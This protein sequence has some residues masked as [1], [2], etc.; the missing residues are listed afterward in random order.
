ML[1]HREITFTR[2]CDELDVDGGVVRRGVAGVGAVLVER[3]RE[4]D[5]AHLELRDLELLIGGHVA[6]AG[7]LLNKMRLDDLM[8]LSD[9]AV[10]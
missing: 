9:E 2:V 10:V 3:R 5:V 1:M 6:L 8:I 4:A 7:A